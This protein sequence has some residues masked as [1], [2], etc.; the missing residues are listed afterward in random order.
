MDR[1]YQD[2]FIEISDDYNQ[3]E[4]GGYIPPRFISWI[5]ADKSRRK[6]KP[7]SNINDD[8]N[9]PQTQVPRNDEIQKLK[10]RINELDETIESIRSDRDGLLRVL[11]RT[12]NEILDHEKDELKKENQRLKNILQRHGLPTETV[13]IKL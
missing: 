11:Q 10:N 3:S 9:Q 13:N 6:S 12:R 7:S 2:W 4:W 8:D 1:Q 5:C